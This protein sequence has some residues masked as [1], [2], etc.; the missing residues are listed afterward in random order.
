MSIYGMDAPREHQVF[1][2]RPNGNRCR[3]LRWDQLLV[4][5]HA[6]F[7][8][9]THPEEAAATMEAVEVDIFS[10]HQNCVD[11][12]G[13]VGVTETCISLVDQGTYVNSCTVLAA[14]L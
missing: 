12:P 7:D 14:Q 10:I 13:D 2:N 5:S 8:A 1:R 9:P 4:L 6:A 11:R 3:L